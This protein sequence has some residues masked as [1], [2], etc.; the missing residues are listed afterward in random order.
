MRLCAFD[1]ETSGLDPENDY[2]TELGYVIKDWGSPK[3]LEVRTIFIHA[4]GRKPLSDHIKSLTKIDDSMTEK[5]G[6]SLDAAIGEM[7]ADI[8]RYA[9]ETMVAHNGK[10]FDLPFLTKQAAYCG[11]TIR[12]PEMI[13]TKVD[14]PYPPHIKA[15]SQVHIAAELGWLNPFPHAACFDAMTC[16]KI[17]DQF[18]I[19]QVYERAR[20][21]TIAI[22][23]MVNYDRKELAKALGYSWEKAGEF[24]H[25]KCWIKAIKESEY[26]AE[27]ARAEESGFD[28]VKA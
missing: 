23:A 28:S 1:L 25:P 14:I 22:R 16:L 10:Q 24:H 9:V 2:I 26:G 12:L 27:K 19:K 20:T 18:D 7:F 8:E 5:Y 21:K 17:L 6:V 11:I 15:R 3:P 4:P 13:D